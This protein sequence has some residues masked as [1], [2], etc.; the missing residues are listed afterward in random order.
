MAKKNRETNINTDTIILVYKGIFQPRMKI[1]A[2]RD[3]ITKGKNSKTL[4]AVTDANP[5]SKGVLLF[6]VK[7]YARKGS[8]PAAPGVMLFPKS[9]ANNIASRLPKG[10]SSFTVDKINFHR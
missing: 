8:P 3:M 9:L 4:S 6:A 10:I 1:A 2:K 7:R 5:I